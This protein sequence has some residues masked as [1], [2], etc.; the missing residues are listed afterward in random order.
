MDNTKNNNIMNFKRL[1]NKWSFM[2]LAGLAL[3][4]TFSCEDDLIE[5]NINPNAINELSYGPQLAKIQLYTT[6][7]RYE[8]RRAA[9]GYGWASIQQL[10]GLE[11]GGS[12]LPG[13]KYQDDQTFG[14]SLFDRVY[15][16]EYKDLADLLN[17]TAEVP[18]A[19]NYNAMAKI[20]SAIS[21]HRTTDFYGDIPYFN[22][23]KGFI[24]NNWFVEYDA[25][26]AIYLDM[27]QNLEEGA[28]AL[29]TSAENPGD[30]DLVH[31]GDIAKW[32]RMAYSYMLRLG[33]RLTKVDPA[34]A[35]TWVKKAIAGGVMTSTDDSVVIPHQEQGG[36]VS[37]NPIGEGFRND[38][39]YRISETLVDW[40]QVNNDPRLDVIGWVESGGA[41]KG[42]PNGYD[43]QTIQAHPSW[44]NILDYSQV[45]PDLVTLSSP[46]I[47]MT[48]A[49]VELMLAEAAVRGWHTGSAAAHYENGIRGAM[50]HWAI[51]DVATPA[52]ADVDAYVAAHPF[53]A[54][55]G[56][57]LIGEQYWMATFLNAWEGYSNWRRVEFPVLTPTNYPGNVTGGTIPRRVRYPASE[58]SINGPNVG[59]AVSRQGPDT[60]T[61]R[62]WWDQ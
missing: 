38:R 47:L 8:I 62:I 27:L 17:R 7:T 1:I 18:E 12:Y 55:N 60:Y 32:R 3:L 4:T 61:T 11:T 58:Y 35:E 46:S 49:E 29:S 24:D 51:Y 13:D 2:L 26:S 15:V 43:Q 56:M 16:N 6:G 59:A 5:L 57:E 36:W 19:V 33:L 34:T 30:Q 31:Q 37:T 44:T 50:D 25:Q 28:S 48:Y 23:G 53:S 22:A 42:M 41:Q 54:A 21:F 39:L 52:A 40:L 45:H 9:W 14:S 10:A 20:W